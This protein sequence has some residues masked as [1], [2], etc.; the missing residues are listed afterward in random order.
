VKLAAPALAIERRPGELTQ[1]LRCRRHFEQASEL[2]TEKDTASSVTCG[3][4]PRLHAQRSTSTST[5]DMTRS[6]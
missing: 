5:R 6:T 1:E 3:P 2:V 4:D